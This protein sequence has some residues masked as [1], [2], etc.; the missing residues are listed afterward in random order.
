M[1]KRLPGDQPNPPHLKAYIRDL[2]NIEKR[3]VICAGLPS[4]G[5]TKKAIE[6]GMELVRRGHFEKVVYIRPYLDLRCGFLPG[7]LEEKMSPY[8]I[9]AESYGEACTQRK[10][11]EM[12]DKVEVCPTDVLQGRR[13]SRCF[14]II[15]ESQNIHESEAFTILSRMGEECKYVVIGDV[16]PGQANKKIGRKNL[17]S[18]CLNKFPNDED[19]ASHTFYEKEHILGDPFTKKVIS[20]LLDDFA[21]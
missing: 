10:F 20:L 4:T 8:T 13:F 5:K 7:T 2:L 14:V 19:I 1:A 11:S 12:R 17:L 6:C 15:D 16:H 18:Y 21:A 3:L 9:Q